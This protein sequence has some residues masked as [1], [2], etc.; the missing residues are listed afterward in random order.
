MTSQLHE[1]GGAGAHLAPPVPMVMPYNCPIPNP[2]CEKR[3]GQVMKIHVCAMSI[4]LSSHI[5]WKGQDNQV[6]WYM[7]TCPQDSPIHPI[8]EG[9]DEVI[10]QPSGTC[11]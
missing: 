5:V 2:M 11:S 7:C 9:Q 8:W 1:S 4:G 3:K 6:Q 10:G